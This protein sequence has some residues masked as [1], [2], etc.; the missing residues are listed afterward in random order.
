MSELDRREVIL[1]SIKAAPR[2]FNINEESQDHSLDA[3]NNILWEARIRVESWGQVGWGLI[4]TPKRNAIK[5]LI[6][7]EE[8]GNQELTEVQYEE[9]QALKELG[10]DPKTVVQLMGQ[11]LQYA[12]YMLQRSIP[13]LDHYKRYQ[14]RQKNFSGDVAPGRQRNYRGR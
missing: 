6:I 9:R 8:Q 12:L 11:S 10:V 4:V 3:L 1:E 5:G 7:S 14:S 13:S 2:F